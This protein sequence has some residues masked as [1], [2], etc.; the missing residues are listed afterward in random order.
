M[1]I[2]GKYLK[3]KCKVKYNSIVA[4]KRNKGKSWKQKKETDKKNVFLK[5]GREVAG[6]KFIVAQSL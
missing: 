6:N 2:W 5:C 1:S 3:W 4:E